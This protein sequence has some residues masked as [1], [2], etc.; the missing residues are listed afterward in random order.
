[1]CLGVFL[2]FT[3]HCVTLRQNKKQRTKPIIFSSAMVP[4][5]NKAFDII[6]FS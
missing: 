2:A 4:L 6:Y 1:M 5:L 3:D